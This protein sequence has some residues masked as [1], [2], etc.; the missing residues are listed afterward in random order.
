MLTHH[1]WW[2]A[3]TR[4]LVQIKYRP[5][6]PRRGL[7]SRPLINTVELDTSIRLERAVETRLKFNWQT[8]GAITLNGDRANFPAVPS[9]PGVWRVTAG[10][11]TEYGASQDLRQLMYQMASPGPTQGTLRRVNGTVTAALAAGMPT[12]LDI[13]TSAEW[14]AGG[15]WVPLDLQRDDLRSLVRAAA[16]AS[17]VTDVDPDP[18]SAPYRESHA[19]A[20]GELLPLAGSDLMKP[21]PAA[22]PPKPDN[23]EVRQMKRATEALNAFVAECD[24]YWFKR[25]GIEG[26]L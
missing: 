13:I 23:A 15:R 2:L 24:R 4:S 8:A 11:D 26:N 25:W 19:A 17:T 7:P 12:T 5:V 21:L 3:G 9:K 22:R 18:D 6:R 10:N 1:R 14:H 16:V 20:R